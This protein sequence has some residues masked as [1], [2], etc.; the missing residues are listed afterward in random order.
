MFLTF[1]VNFS[2]EYC[3]YFNSPNFSNP[4]GTGFSAHYLY[5]RALSSWTN[6]DAVSLFAG[7]NGPITAHGWDVPVA[8]T[9][10]QNLT[11]R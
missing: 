2:G 9:S 1:D 8:S 11:R 10:S 4:N 7:S 5:R 6:F 3:E